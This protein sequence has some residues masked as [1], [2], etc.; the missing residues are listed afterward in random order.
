MSLLAKG[1]HIGFRWT[2][3][4]ITNHALHFHFSYYIVPA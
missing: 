2:A 4:D 1:S 3:T